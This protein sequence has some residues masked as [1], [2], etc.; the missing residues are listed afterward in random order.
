M[1]SRNWCFTVNNPADTDYPESWQLDYVKNMIY[2][3]EIG[4][5]GTLHLQG[6]LELKN[7]RNLTWLKR[8]MH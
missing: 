5:N 2:Q 6:Y 3:V 8:Q 4:E 1:S 7:P